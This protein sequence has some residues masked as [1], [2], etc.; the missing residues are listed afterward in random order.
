MFAGEYLLG[1]MMMG[2]SMQSTDTTPYQCDGTPITGNP[3]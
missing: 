1:G 2:P 3:P